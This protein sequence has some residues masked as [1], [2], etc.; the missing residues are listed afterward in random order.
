MIGSTTLRHKDDDRLGC[1]GLGPRKIEHVALMGLDLA[2][3]TEAETIEFVLEALEGGRGGWICPVNLDV[4][5]QIVDSGELRELVSSADLIV[6]DGMPLVWAAHLQGTPL[7][8]RVAGST[9]ILT[10]SEELGRHGRSVYLLGGNEGTA[11][12]AGVRL[13]E[14]LAGFRLAGWFCPPLGFEHSAE[15][16]ELITTHL[17]GAEPD[18]VFVGLGFPKQDRLIAQLRRLLPRAWFVSCGISLSFLVG[19]V[20]RAP[21]AMQVLGLEWTHRLAQEP[22]RLTKRYLIHGLPFAARLAASSV[23]RRRS[24][25]AQRDSL[26]ADL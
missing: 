12:A 4:L 20:H 23:Y 9:L 7:P 3:L 8:E 10:L 22:T 24:N 21:R 1:A 14:T 11:Q 2:P 17:K 6:A 25:M 16:L 13:Q 5:R 15:Q 26:T 19:E 18:V